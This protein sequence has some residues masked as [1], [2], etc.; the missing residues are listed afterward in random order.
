MPA[1]RTLFAVGRIVPRMILSMFRSPDEGSTNTSLGLER[2][3]RTSLEALSWLGVELEVIGVE[4]V[5]RSGGLVFMWNQQSHLDHFALGAAIP[6]PFF[7]L[8]N[9]ELGRFPIYGRYL[10][11]S[12]HQLVDRRDETQWRRSVSEA[13]RRVHAGESVLV[14]PEGTRSWDGRLLPMK[15]GAFILYEEA[16]RPLICVTLVGGN[17]RLGRGSA[18]VR[19][20][21]LRVVFS[22][23][24]EPGDA[25]AAKRCVVETF[26]RTLFSATVGDRGA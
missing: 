2:V 7:S 15:R 5:P 12:G 6:R 14:S 13:A 19:S 24:L 4:R 16:A 8:F 10:E 23:P 1:A 17:E 22:E 26:E 20:G 9:L 25:E 3:R 11:R 21:R 18:I